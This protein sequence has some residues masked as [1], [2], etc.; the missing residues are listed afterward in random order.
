MPVLPML[1]VSSLPCWPPPIPSI[2]Y[3]GSEK[4]LPPITCTNSIRWMNSAE[5]FD[6]IIFWCVDS[7][8]VL[9]NFM[10]LLRCASFW[11]LIP[12]QLYDFQI[13]ISSSTFLS[14]SLPSPLPCPPLFHHRMGVIALIKTKICLGSQIVVNF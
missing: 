13:N 4:R 7:S 10:R 14:S 6:S 8:S 3:F 12:F 1:F 5:G 2:T 9:K 11:I